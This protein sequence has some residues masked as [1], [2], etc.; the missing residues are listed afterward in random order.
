[1]ATKQRSV[2]MHDVHD[3]DSF[4][5]EIL[6]D[7]LKKRQAFLRRELWED[8]HSYLLEVVLT[9]APKWDSEKH[10]KFS[11][12]VR[13]VVTKRLVDWYRK[14]LGDSRYKTKRPQVI[15]LGEWAEDEIGEH[16]FADQSNTKVSLER[17]FAGL[18][19]KGKWI[20]ENIA[21]PHSEGHSYSEIATIHDKSNRWVR[22]QLAALKDELEVAGVGAW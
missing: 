14:E 5:G 11:D 12:W 1:M 21:T 17:A 2:R 4:V 7:Q 19:E 22:E 18:S 15:S 9:N 16:D 6:N 13:V 8:A 10:P 20:L 3:I